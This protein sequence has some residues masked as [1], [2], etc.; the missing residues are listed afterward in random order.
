MRGEGRGRSHRTNESYNPY[1]AVMYT[2]ALHRV[3]SCVKYV[4]G[5]QRGSAQPPVS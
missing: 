1:I 5:Q 2:D 4:T 3:K